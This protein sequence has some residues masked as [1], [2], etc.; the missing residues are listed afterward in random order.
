MKMPTLLLALSLAL[1]ALAAAADE[2]AATNNSTQAK[3]TYPADAFGFLALNVSDV[4]RSA[5][6]Y[7]D[8]VGLTIQRRFVEGDAR[9]V[10]L[11][12]R[13]NSSFPRLALAQNLKRDKPYTLGDGYSRCAFFVPDLQAVL[14]RAS[15][16]GVKTELQTDSQA[17]RL[18]V[19]ILKDP[20][21]YSVELL[22]GY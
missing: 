8:V 14:K 5:T 1:S 16:A 21:G 15:A 6:F 2:L 17:T 4:E 10:F 12:V 9:Y 22:Q 19:A 11:D 13:G 7:T 3:I 18:K 20:D